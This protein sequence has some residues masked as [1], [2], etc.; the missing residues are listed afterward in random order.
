MNHD[1]VITDPIVEKFLSPKQIKKQE[2][3]KIHE[4]KKAEKKRKSTN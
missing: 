2:K 4:F 1:I 3:K